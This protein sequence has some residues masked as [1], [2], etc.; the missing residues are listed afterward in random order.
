M[1]DFLEQTGLFGTL[2]SFEWEELLKITEERNYTEGEIIFSEGDE[3]T[4]LCILL[5]GEVEIQIKI[6]PQLAET[7]VYRVKPYEA[8][9]EFAFV[10]PKPR[11]ATARCAKNS[12][13]AVIKR[14]NFE[15]LVRNFP[16]VGTNFYKSLVCILSNRVRRTNNFLKDTLIR[17]LGMEI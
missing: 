5:N 15:E 10:D 8:F 3:S 1:K 13:L 14:S 4:E 17:A 7:T 2:K 16:H 12:T 6:A 9:G 11:S